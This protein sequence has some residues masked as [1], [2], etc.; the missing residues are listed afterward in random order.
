[1][2]RYDIIIS[3]GGMIGSI[4]A[5]AACEKG[6]S[7]LL[8]EAH[9]VVSLAM[10]SSAQMRVSA[11]SAENIAYLKDLEI[12]INLIESRIQAYTKMQ[13]WDN[14]GSGH[15]EFE[16]DFSQQPCLGYLLENNNLVQAAWMTLK[17]QPHCDTIVENAIDVIENDEMQIR[18]SMKNGDQYKA[19]LLLA[20]EGRNSYV[21]QQL[22]IKTEEKDYGQK[23]LVAYI[24]LAKAPKNTA[25][26]AFNQGGPLGILPV[27][28]RKNIFS[29]VWSLP[30]DEC[31]QWL[32]C[33]NKTFES[34]IKAA[35]GRDFGPIE[36][37][38]ER[39]AFPLTQ[40][41]ALEYFKNRT[42]LAGDSAHGVHPLAGQGVNLGIGDIRQLFELLDLPILKDKYLLRIALRKYQ[43]R[44]I[45]QVRETS[46]MMSFLHQLFK[47]DK[48]LKKPLRNM[49]MNVLNKLPVKK[50]FAK[51][52]GS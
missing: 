33:D 9:K 16:A 12:Y 31:Q 36:L 20:A 49:G 2:K 24:K 8:I 7:V 28:E 41:Y 3:G 52:A 1:M 19:R 35:I 23:G 51:Q 26:Q 44:R 40:L 21:R 4:A 47:D 10:D 15:I 46:E 18:V 43:R 50:W 22:N 5:V 25:L 17:A 11:I 27:N 34:A 14:R 42:V 38:S 48:Y 39:L 6:L 37:L 32:D 29:I 30:K 13:V 45:S